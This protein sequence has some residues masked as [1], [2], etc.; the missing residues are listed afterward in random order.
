MQFLDATAV[1]AALPFGLLV[2]ALRRG[3]AEGVDEIGRLL[4]EQRGVEEAADHFLIWAGWMRGRV[5]GAKLVTVFP[6]N[7][8]QSRPPIAAVYVLF[9]GRDGAPLAVLDGTALTL[10]K[11]AADSALG[12]DYLARADVRTLLVIGAGN[13]APWQVTALHAVRPSLAQALVWNRTFSRA[14]LLAET[15][16][17]SGLKAEAV[18]DLPEAVA[19][20]D[21]ITC[22]TAATEPVLAGN[23][24]RPGT[25][26]DLV[27][28]FTPMMREADDALIRRA[29]VFADTRRFTVGVCGDIDAPVRSGLLAPD[30]IADLFDLAQGR[31]RG[32]QTADEITVFKNG[33]GGHL[34]LMTARFAFERHTGELVTS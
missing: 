32:R 6:A 30:A 21:L 15:L 18:A 25:H 3:H 10:R 28:G 31:A 19:R 23:W 20:A 12:A 22:A 17:R 5:L 7:A 2:E 11:T 14:A 16:R 1:H 34:D 24:V 9:N 13:Q 8:A 26:V 27:G 4:L 29:R 33:G